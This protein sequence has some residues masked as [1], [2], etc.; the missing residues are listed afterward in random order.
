MF[1]YNSWYNLAS[2]NLESLFPRNY[3]DVWWE[4]HVDFTPNPQPFFQKKPLQVK[5][6]LILS[7][8]KPG[9]PNSASNP[10]YLSPI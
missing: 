10:N 6:L 9:S 1:I 7:E 8:I 3:E 4:A 5:S 2:P